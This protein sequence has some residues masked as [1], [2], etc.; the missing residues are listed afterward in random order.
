MRLTQDIESALGVAVTAVTA[1]V[2]VAPCP[3]ANVPMVV[4]AVCMLSLATAFL[5][6][7]VP[8]AIA[9]SLAYVAFTMQ[10]RL[11]KTGLPE[12]FT[13]DVVDDRVSTPDRKASVPASYTP[14]EPGVAKVTDTMTREKLEALISPEHLEAAQSN[15]VR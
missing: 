15:L 11:C 5:L 4:I 2:A 10:T 13:V 12:R 8:L 7:S 14:L 3:L 6:R 9:V 1:F